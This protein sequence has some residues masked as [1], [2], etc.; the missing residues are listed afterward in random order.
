MATRHGN[1]P[2]PWG[3]PRCSTAEWKKLRAYILERDRRICHVCGQ[4]GATEVDHLIPVA[5]GGTDHPL[6]LR[7]I[8]QRPCH[9]RKSA[10]EAARARSSRSTTRSPETHPGVRQATNT[11]R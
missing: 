5:E 11:R 7:A 1:G 2:N 10:A 9:A 6:N 8:H 3:S 4:G